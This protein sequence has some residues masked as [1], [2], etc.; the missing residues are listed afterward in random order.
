MARKL[1]EHRKA[2]ASNASAYS[3][4]IENKM[5]RLVSL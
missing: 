5:E 2:I 1:L 4:E 3:Y